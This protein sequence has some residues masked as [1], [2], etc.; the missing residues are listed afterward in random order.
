MA[1][2][3]LRISALAEQQLRSI[4]RNDQVRVLRSV[5]RLVDDPRPRGCRKLHG[6]LDTFRI[7]VGYYRVVYAVE[8]SQLLVLVVKVGHRKDIYR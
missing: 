5:L 1:R 8:D 6:S 4:P 7:R 2:Y 3:S